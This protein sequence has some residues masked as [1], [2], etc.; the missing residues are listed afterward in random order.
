LTESKGVDTALRV[1][2]RVP[3]LHLTVAGGGDPAYA[4][5]LRALAAQLSV[6]DRVDWLGSQPQAEIQRL[7]SRH[8]ALLFPI[9]WDEPWGKVPL[10]AMASG[11]PVVAIARGGSAEYLRDGSNCLAGVSE[12]DLVQ[13]LMRLADDAGLRETLAAGGTATAAANDVAR[14]NHLRE[15]ALM[16]TI[17]ESARASRQRRG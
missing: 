7:Y 10:E 16:Q 1:L 13:A 5:E 12:D 17:A 4:A 2:S 11:L 9:R 14:A 6:A 8:D 3:S 15:K